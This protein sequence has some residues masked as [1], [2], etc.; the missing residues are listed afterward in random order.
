MKR[1]Q[2]IVMKRRTLLLV[3]VCLVLAGETPRDEAA[4]KDLEWMQ[5]DWQAVSRVVD[6]TPFPDDDAQSMFRTVKGDQYTIFLF[7]K[8]L[9]KG[10]MKLDATKTPRAI[11]ALPEGPAG[12]SGPIL[13]I[14]EI[15]GD[16]L[17][18]CFAQ[19]GK[20]R[21]KDFACKAGS[22]HNLTVWTREKK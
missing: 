3:A 11:D 8:P 20:E 10:K 22:G 21:P 1:M 15:S 16:T 9:G 6:G 4:R 17:K 7:Q 13:G 5:G 2:G 12:K 18:M 14:Y 19:P